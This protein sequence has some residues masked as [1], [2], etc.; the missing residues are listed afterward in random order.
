MLWF[1]G[2]VA[3]HRAWCKIQNQTYHVGFTGAVQWSQH[4]GCVME[5]RS[6]SSPE[7]DRRSTSQSP[8]IRFVKSDASSHGDAPDPLILKIFKIANAGDAGFWY[9]NKGQ[10]CYV[11]YLR[12]QKIAKKPTGRNETDTHVECAVGTLDG[13]HSLGGSNFSIELIYLTVKQKRCN[14]QKIP[15]ESPS[16][17]SRTDRP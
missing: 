10:E 12:R 3:P 16:P 17:S 8:F 9:F 6:W 15:R 2:L 14:Q 4:P 5:P 11:T 1:L 7:Q 13:I